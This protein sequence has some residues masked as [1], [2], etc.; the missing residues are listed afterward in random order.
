MI[1]YSSIFFL[2]LFVQSRNANTF[3]AVRSRTYSFDSSP[4]TDLS[5]GIDNNTTPYW[6]SSKKVTIQ[7]HEITQADSTYKS[8]NNVCVPDDSGTYL[9]APSH[10]KRNGRKVADIPL[11]LLVTPGI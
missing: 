6:D 5:Y 7:R 8:Y 11:D 9:V 3:F 10:V 4:A 1:R 2:N